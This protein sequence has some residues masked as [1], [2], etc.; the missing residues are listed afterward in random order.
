MPKVSDLDL[1]EKKIEILTGARTCFATYGY[2]GAT[3]ARLEE[4]T[5]KSRGAI[6]HH[7]GNKDALFLAVAHE[8]MRRMSAIAA[9]AGL[10]GLIRELV[11]SHDLTEWWGMR[12]EITRRANN[13]PCFSAK[14]ELDQLALQQTVRD[15]LREQARQGRIRTDVP[16]DTIAEVL[17]L[18]MEGV[19]SKLAQ[20]VLSPDSDLEPALDFVETALR[21]HPE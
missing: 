7:Y 14:W 13:D 9:R 19:L 12:V 10:I 16:V 1:T 18:V 11:D 20:G 8:D 17:E 4:A 15:R 2:D 21:R 5:G 6:F 3:V